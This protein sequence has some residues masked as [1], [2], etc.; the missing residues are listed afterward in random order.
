MFYTWEDRKVVYVNPWIAALFVVLVLAVLGWLNRDIVSGWFS[1]VTPAPA[2]AINGEWVGTMQ[3][4][5][6]HDPF[7]RDIHKDAVIIFNLHIT[8]SIVKKYGGKG[9]LTI[10]GEPPR[11]IKI[12]DLWSSDRESSVKFDA[13]LWLV[14]YHQGDKGD[15]ISGGFS[16]T[17][18]P[19]TLTLQRDDFEGY[20]MKGTL[21]KGNKAEYDQLVKQMSTGSEIHN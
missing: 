8:D 7:L 5:G 12:S 21:H 3:I 1:R 13:G 2:N 15:L 17:F 6:I 19:G 14:P 16:G 18:K 4:Y 9:E 11:P 10:V 20:A